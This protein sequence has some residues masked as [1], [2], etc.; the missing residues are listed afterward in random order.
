MF[1]YPLKIPLR[2][3]LGLGLAKLELAGLGLGSGFISPIPLARAGSNFKHPGIFCPGRYHK[4]P[5]L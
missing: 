3:E 4:L 5:T 1:K 2:L